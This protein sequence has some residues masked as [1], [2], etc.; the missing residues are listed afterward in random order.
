MATLEIRSATK[1]IG[2]IKWAYSRYCLTAGVSIQHPD[3]KGEVWIE[4]ARSGDLVTWK[5]GNLASG[6]QYEHDQFIDCYTNKE[7]P[8]NLHEY[9][10]NYLQLAA[11]KPADQWSAAE[12]RAVKQRNR[13]S[14]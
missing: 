10:C 1:A 7:A 6:D 8:K 12:K 4:V 13:R 11:L 2:S 3:I 5:S 14:K 9:A